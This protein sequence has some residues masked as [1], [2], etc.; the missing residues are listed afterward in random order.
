MS[1]PTGISGQD[2]FMDTEII[3]LKLFGRTIE[4]SPAP[5]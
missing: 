1:L 2:Y 5:L 3:V 4:E